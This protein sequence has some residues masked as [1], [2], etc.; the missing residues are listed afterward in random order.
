MLLYM[1]L[2]IYIQLFKFMSNFSVDSSLFDSDNGYQSKSCLVSPYKRNKL[3][4]QYSR[5]SLG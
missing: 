1:Y 2:Y 5:Q 3:P 4:P